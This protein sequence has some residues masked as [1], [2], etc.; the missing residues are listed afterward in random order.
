MTSNLCQR[1]PVGGEEERPA[2]CPASGR[3]GREVRWLTGRKERERERGRE[4][5]SA[6][7]MQVSEWHNRS[8]KVGGIR[9]DCLREQGDPGARQ[10]PRVSTSLSHS[11]LVPSLPSTYPFLCRSVFPRLSSSSPAGWLESVPSLSCAPTEYMHVH[12]YSTDAR[13]VHRFAT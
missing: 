9:R 6:P 7:G 11:S 5:G 2:A 3:A 13:V 12:V 4:R 8:A 1:R 10:L